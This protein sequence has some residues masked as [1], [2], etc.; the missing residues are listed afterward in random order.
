[1]SAALEVDLRTS[2]AEAGGGVVTALWV[3]IEGAVSFE[4]DSVE[5]VKAKSVSAETETQCVGVNKIKW[6]V[7]YHPS[8]QQ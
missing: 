4:L 5:F 7:I 1:V 6:D 2:G 3:V 8:Q